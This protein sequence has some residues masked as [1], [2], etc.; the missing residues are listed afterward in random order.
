MPVNV[1]NTTRKYFE[2]NGFSEF[3]NDPC[4]SGYMDM[5]DFLYH[6]NPLCDYYKA[7]LMDTQDYIQKKL[8]LKFDSYY[9]PAD[10]PK[11]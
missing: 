3:K 10:L 11:C 8:G 6:H 2:E 5:S 7:A 1:P 4:V 9:F